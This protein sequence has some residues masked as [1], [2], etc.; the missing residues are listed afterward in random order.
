[1]PSGNSHAYSK[2][3]TQNTTVL[4]TLFFNDT[5]LKTVCVNDS[6]PSTSLYK[7]INK[8][9]DISYGSV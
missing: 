8:K 1:M 5:D 3:S 4:F 2:S 9:S 7:K 6:F